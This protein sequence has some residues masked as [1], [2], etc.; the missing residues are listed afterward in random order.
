MSA[1]AATPGRALTKWAAGDAPAVERVKPGS[2]HRTGA[3]R[4]PLIVEFVGGIAGVGKTTI[5]RSCRA[6][7]ASLGHTVYYHRDVNHL[8]E[9]KGKVQ[10]ALALL[11]A[12]LLW[13]LLHLTL[14]SPPLIRRQNE[15]FLAHR[16]RCALEMRKSFVLLY[17]FAQHKPNSILILDQWICRKLDITDENQAAAVL[18]FI[19]C[20][21]AYFDKHYLFVDV[22]AA[23][24]ANRVCQREWRIQTG[25]ERGKRMDYRLNLNLVTQ[26]YKQKLVSYERLHS[27]FKAHGLRVSRLDGGCPPDENAARIVQEIIEPYVNLGERCNAR[28]TRS[29]T[30]NPVPE[31]PLRG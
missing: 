6:L 5:A 22:P 12:P 27:R 10:R 24:A 25:Q 13:R 29:S 7:A 16:W 17:E 18:R 4:P 31:A 30:R 28:H 23:V 14:R 9:S 2:E 11:R 3:H 20:F 26:L 19:A 8:F 21:D 1:T 15:S